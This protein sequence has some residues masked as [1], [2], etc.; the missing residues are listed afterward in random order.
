MK[1]E[2]T[3]KTW[4][5]LLFVAAAVSLLNALAALAGA[6]YSL[7]ESIAFCAEG[8]AVLFLAAQ[9]GAPKT[10]KRGYFGVF[11]LLMLSYVLAGWLGYICAAAVWPALL[12]V[13][14][15]RGAPIER[16]MRLVGGAEVLHLAF[17]LA[18]LY[19]RLSSLQFWA[20]LLWALLACARGWAAMSLY[21]ATREEHS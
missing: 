18:S 4:Y 3:R 5:A 2:F 17:V 19:G 20:N 8:L 13:E 6:G 16:Q 15:K 21:K 12:Y 11:V 14:Y 1:L 10:E 7:L 9:K